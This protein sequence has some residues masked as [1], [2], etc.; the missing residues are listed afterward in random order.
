MFLLR[1]EKE[2]KKK[3]TAGG[4]GQGEN[5]YHWG[6]GCRAWLVGGRH[7]VTGSLAA[8]IASR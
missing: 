3:K 2:K 1:G 4:L 8:K 6:R 5:R 7:P